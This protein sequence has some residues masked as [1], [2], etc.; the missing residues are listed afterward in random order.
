MKTRI[1]SYLMVC[2]AFIS[3]SSCLDDDELQKDVTDEI[4]MTVS[5]VTG[6]M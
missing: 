1:L 3:L 6:M 2:M 5:S 4:S